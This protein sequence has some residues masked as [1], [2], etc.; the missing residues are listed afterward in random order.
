MSRSS[1]K[2]TSRNRLPF[3]W[4]QMNLQFR[5]RAL[6]FFSFGLLVF[7]PAAFSAVGF[8]LARMAG[9]S[10]PDLL[11]VIIGGG[12]M[13]L[14]SNLVFS[15]FFDISN[16]RREGTLE[17]IVGSPTSF[18]T[19]LAVRTFS[20]VLTGTISTA[21]SFLVAALFFHFS[22]PA[23]NLPYILLSLLVLL[24]GFWC[25]GLFLAHFRVWSRL[26]GTLI[27]YLELPVAILAAF[28]FPIEYL[29]KWIM[30]LADIIPI[31]WG[32]VALRGAFQPGIDLSAWWMNLA[33]AAG[34]SAVY[35]LI[36]LFLSR[37]VHDMI[38]VSGELSSI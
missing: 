24:F 32:V 17:F 25:M 1:N 12:I 4:T 7:Q 15:S 23:A 3:I 29:P 20:N 36:A 2:T 27:N 35:F 19:V 11:Y 31:R 13:G 22:F 14:W 9:K 21:L 26:S 8:L 6:S 38:R 10:T 16:D 33:L 30:W 37:K 28:M 34:V 18:W 5:S